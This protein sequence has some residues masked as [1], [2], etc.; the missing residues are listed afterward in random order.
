[1]N[2]LK[3][4]LTA[5]ETLE[6]L[7]NQWASTED[8]MK[9]AFVGITKAGAIKKE[10]TNKVIESGKTLPK[11]LIPMEQL[12]DYLGINISYLKKVSSK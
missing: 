7:N 4:K 11:G 1:M 12:Q 8:I 5:S 9:L 10:I 3:R 2:K 6:L